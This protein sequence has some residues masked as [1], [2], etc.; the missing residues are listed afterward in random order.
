MLKI[1]RQKI[2]Q[3]IPISASRKYRIL[4]LFHSKLQFLNDWTLLREIRHHVMHSMAIRL[5]LL[6]TKQGIVRKN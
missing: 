3:E 6:Q 2:K 5:L 1:L 4:I